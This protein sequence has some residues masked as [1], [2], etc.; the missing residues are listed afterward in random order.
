[1]MTENDLKTMGLILS[2]DEC[3]GL[4]RDV[5]DNYKDK[6]KHARTYASKKACKKSIAFYEAVQYHLERLKKIESETKN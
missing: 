2:L 1:M 6:V 3:I 4:V 5:C